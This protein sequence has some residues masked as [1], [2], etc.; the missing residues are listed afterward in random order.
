MM[1][2]KTLGLDI[3]EDTV[4][5]V[6]VKGGLQSNQVMACASA[7]IA[8]E[9]SREQAL[10]KVLDQI[11]LHGVACISGIPSEKVSY[12]N[13]VLPFKDTRKIDQTIAF[14]LESSLPY[15]VDEVLVDFI[16]TGQENDQTGVLAAAVKRSYLSEYLGFLESQ[17]ISPE[18]L[19][20]RNVPTG[21]LLLKQPDVPENGLFI[22][23]R[24]EKATVLLFLK[25][26]IVMVRKLNFVGRIQ[27]EED[28][29]RGIRREDVEEACKRF[30]LL[31]R[32]T[33]LSF[34]NESKDTGKP[35]KVYVSGIRASDS[36]VTDMLR[37]FLQLDVEKVDLG[38]SQSLTFTDQAASQWDPATMNGALA[39]ALRDGRQGLGF[40]FR[41]EEF[42]PKQQ[43]L[44][45][46]KDIRNGAIVLAVILALVM[47]DFG[48]DYFGMKKRYTALD[49][50][51]RSIFA[52]TLPEVKRVVDP[53]QQLRVAVNEMK[54][55]AGISASGSGA[56]SVLDLL[57]DISA[58]IPK[59]KDVIVARMV[60]DQEGIVIKGATD[61]FNTVDTV[62]Q[63]LDGS[64]YFR[65]VTIS[66]ANLDR[67]GNRV[68]FEMR[69][70]LN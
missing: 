15:G 4:T 10:Q 52:R 43:F 50:E 12:R 41:K 58:R 6:L 48:L 13:L 61:T 37:E 46:R 57:D 7:S 68:Q 53:L 44:K 65:D 25:K 66:S 49:Q 36:T 11:D 18:V 9:G 62:K 34:V 40:N 39:F 19:D 27:G 5:A 30:C 32:N 23:L 33:L 20:I 14:E 64:D 28:P 2:G 59:S 45:F 54:R 69:L 16:V 3:I 60:I 47:I 22:D 26:H 8:Q 63:E 17:G 24:E 38:Q 55:N 70:L 21:K 42:E 1:I 31:I 51:V 29:A 67:S 56:Q 35:E